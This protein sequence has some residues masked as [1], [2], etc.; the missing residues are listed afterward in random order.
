LGV[1]LGGVVINKVGGYND[2][3]ALKITILVM[4]IGVLFGGPAPMFDSYIIFGICQWGQFF[5][6]GFAI[7]VVTVIMLNTV[8]TSLRT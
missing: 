6:G 5:C 7:P 3:R 1:F 4:F 8:P 2:P